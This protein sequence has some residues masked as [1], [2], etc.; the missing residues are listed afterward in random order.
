MIERLQSALYLNL[1]DNPLGVRLGAGAVKAG[2][3]GKLSVPLHVR[4]PVDGITFLPQQGGDFANL[5]VAVMTRDQRRAK[6][7]FKQEGY[8]L[9]RPEGSGPDLT[10]SLVIELELEAGIHTIAFGVRDEASQVASY[11]ATGVD[12]QTPAGVAGA[13]D[14]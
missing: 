1:M 4:I 14:P 13:E 8:R 7:S 9:P 12:L 11:V 6:S 3:K 5:R 2:K 10:V